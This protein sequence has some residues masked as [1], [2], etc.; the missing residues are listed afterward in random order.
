MQ[1]WLYL[2]NLTANWDLTS[3]FNRHNAKLWVFFLLLSFLFADSQRR[4][5]AQ[6][7]FHCVV[8]NV[9]ASVQVES[10]SIYRA[11]WVILIWKQLFPRHQAVI[12]LL[13]D[14]GLFFHCQ[15]HSVIGPV[16]SVL[17][18]A[19]DRPMI[20]RSNTATRPRLN[21]ST[22]SQS[23]SSQPGDSDQDRDQ[24][25]VLLHDLHYPQLPP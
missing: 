1:R 8:E 5:C 15:A 6:S 4:S 18:A 14:F 21:H 11:W 19:H 9:I 7:S 3:A 25:A 17:W 20:N 22:I 2:S 24:V 16:G 13:N 10:R 12:W 23:V